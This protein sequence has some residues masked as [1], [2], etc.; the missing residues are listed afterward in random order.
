MKEFLETYLKAKLEL[1]I[2]PAYFPFT[3]PDVEFSIS[4]PFCDKKGCSTCGYSGWIELVPGGMIHPNVLKAGG[5]DPEKYS[6]FAWGLGLDRLVM[7]KNHISEIRE[8]RA[9]NI[10][11]LRKY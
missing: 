8:L 10:K 3:E 1:K 9:G 4:C 11:F 7:I 2:Q 6:G 5:I